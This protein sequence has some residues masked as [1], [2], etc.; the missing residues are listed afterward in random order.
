MSAGNQRGRDDFQSSKKAG[1]E[2][3]FPKAAHSVYSSC[4]LPVAFWGQLRGPVPLVCWGGSLA[5]E[6]G[7]CIVLP[8][9]Q[10]VTSCWLLEV[11]H[12]ESIYTTEMSKSYQS[13][14]P[15]F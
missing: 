3:R 4:D 12:S 13:G 11:S 2:L 9:L 10:S 7:F 14:S 8:T 1:Q 15:F 6:S 5:C